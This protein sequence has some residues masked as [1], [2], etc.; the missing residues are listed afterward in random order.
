MM[1][2]G[3]SDAGSSRSGSRGSGSGGSGGL[4]WWLVVCG[5][6][7]SGFGG[8][9]IFRRIGKDDPAS[10]LRQRWDGLDK[11]E[12]RQQVRLWACRLSVCFEHLAGRGQTQ[13]GR[14]QGC[15]ARTCLPQADAQVAQQQEQLE[16]EEQQEHEE[17]LR[18]ER[19]E[20]QRLAAAVAQVAGA[21]G[22]SR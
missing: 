5:G 13:A 19:E 20:Q 11:S 17:Q 16:F 22:S 3:S 2:R 1:T 8:V 7:V 12:Q 15:C 18:W 6:V 21:V 10:E 4:P 14:W 9:A